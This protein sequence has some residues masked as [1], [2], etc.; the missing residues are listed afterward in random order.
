MCAT[1]SQINQQHYQILESLILYSWI[2]PVD[3]I[4]GLS[5]KC[6]WIK[7]NLV[8]FCPLVN[9]EI[10]VESKSISLFYWNYSP[11]PYDP[12]QMLREYQ[13]LKATEIL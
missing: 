12:R 6:E 7:Y 4:D 5:A 13:F 2:L 9:F 8:F 3:S 11:E 10:Q 1:T